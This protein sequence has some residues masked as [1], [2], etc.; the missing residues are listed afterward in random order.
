MALIQKEGLPVPP[1]SSCTFCP[2]NTLDEWKQLFREEPKKFAEAVELSRNSQVTAPD[3]VGL[4]RCSRHGERQL[5]EWADG[6]YESKPTDPLEDCGD[7]D[8][9]EMPCECAL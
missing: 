1:K 4:M 8:N 9:E 5:H 7:V 2:N 6:K 3:T